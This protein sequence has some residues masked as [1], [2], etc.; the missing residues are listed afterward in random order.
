LANERQGELGWEAL[1]DAGQGIPWGAIED[2]AEA[3]ATRRLS[4]DG[5][6][7]LYRET[8]LPAAGDPDCTPLSVLAALA[9]AAP[10]L[11]PGRRARIVAFFLEELRE[12]GRNA[13]GYL[14]DALIAACGT[15][16]PGSLPAVLDVLARTDA[17]DAAW[18]HLWTL[19]H[20]ATETTDRK[21]RERAAL[22]CEAV[23][24]SAERGEI[25]THMALEAAWALALLK[26]R[27]NHILLRRI[28]KKAD[29]PILRR[30]Y[31]E[32]I[33]MLNGMGD[34]ITP[35]EW[36]D[37]EVDEWLEMCWDTAQ[38]W[39][40]HPEDL[41]DWDEE[42]DLSEPGWG[43]IR[44]L[45]F[46]ALADGVDVEDVTALRAYLQER[47]AG[48]AH[49]PAHAGEDAGGDRRPLPV[50]NP[51]FMTPLDAPCPCGSG[52]KFRECCGEAYTN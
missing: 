7:E 23:V 46:E 27:E 1:R 19:T 5:A 12:A 50:L 41:D 20:L 10:D 22:A 36:W 43:L 38:E 32:I 45:L 40:E 14:M 8:C 35:P 2:L 33:A 42:E 13:A 48:P 18:Y 51:S 24:E 29:C 30:E 47:F 11:E 26:R 37:L 15:V 31:S 34:D 17:S 4:L 25:E 39:P 21:L 52:K 44:E 9:L 3:L 49:L 16:G 6:F 28:R